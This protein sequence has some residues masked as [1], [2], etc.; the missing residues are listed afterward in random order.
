MQYYI[1]H[2]PSLEILFINHFGLFKHNFITWAILL[3][4]FFREDMTCYFNINQFIEKHFEFSYA[5]RDMYIQ[6]DGAA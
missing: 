5:W 3:L 1:L 4:V 6:F 2:R